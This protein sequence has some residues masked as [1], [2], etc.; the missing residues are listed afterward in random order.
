LFEVGFGA[1]G[2]WIG[3]MIFD[4]NRKIRKTQVQSENLT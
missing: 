1:L 4:P 3:A 2:G